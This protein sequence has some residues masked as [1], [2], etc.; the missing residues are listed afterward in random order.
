MEKIKLSEAIRRGCLVHPVQ[1]HWCLF[2]YST[3]NRIV[4]SC[5]LGA[6]A[7]AV[8]PEAA[9]EYARKVI[10]QGRL[11]SPSHIPWPTEEMQKHISTDLYFYLDYDVSDVVRRFV[12]D[13]DVGITFEG[14]S[15]EKFTAFLNDELYMERKDIAS[16]LE[17]IGC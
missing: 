6:A 11:A 13:L 2:D 7:V 17:E 14:M 12:P 16:V 10:A 1:A 4:A 15:V 9:Q 5:A 3:D 8:A